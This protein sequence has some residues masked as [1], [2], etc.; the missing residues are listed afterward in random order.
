MSALMDSIAPAASAVI[1]SLINGL[2]RGLLLTLMVWFLL[3][4]MRRINAATRFV[5]WW[6]ALIA[7]VALPLLGDRLSVAAPD[8]SESAGD[9]QSIRRGSISTA[10]PESA[11][12]RIEGL[13]EGSALS[14]PALSA[15]DSSDQVQTNSLVIPVRFLNGRWTAILFSLWL[16]GSLVMLGRV[17]RSYFHLR[18]LKRRMSPLPQ[19]HTARLALCLKKSIRRVEIG[20]S[21]E[22]TNP[23]VAGFARPTILIPDSLVGE[24]TESEFDTVV[25]HELAHIRRWDDWLN[26]AQKIIEAILFFN[27]SV[28]W[29]GRQISLEREIACDDRVVSATGQ[30]KSYAACLL[31]L[32][33]IARFR[34]INLLAPGAV[35]TRNQISRRIEML[36]DRKRNST[37][38]LSRAMISTAI[39]LLAFAVIKGTEVLP[40]LAL[41]QTAASTI[42]GADQITID[43]PTYRPETSAIQRI[44][45]PSEPRYDGVQQ[46]PQ[47][48]DAARQEI[49]EPKAPSPPSLPQFMPSLPQFVP[50]PP[51][52]VAVPPVYPVYPSEKD[53]ARYEEQK[54]KYEEQMRQYE[55]EMAEYDKQMETYNAQMRQYEKEMA[56]YEKQMKV[57]EEQMRRYEE[58]MKRYEE[59]MRQFEQQIHQ[60]VPLVVRRLISDEMSKID[61]DARDRIDSATEQVSSIIAMELI[62]KFRDLKI[63]RPGGYIAL[64]SEMT[65]KE[66]QARLRSLFNKHDLKL[67]S[68]TKAEFDAALDRLSP[69]LQWLVVYRFEK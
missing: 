43:Q 51:R 32:I 21:N 25:L 8:A 37:V 14:M 52:L 39:A 48:P 67:D 27:P 66:I 42:T 56:E 2:V 50:S 5:V 41:D 63:N 1:G 31:K 68:K 3:G 36:M 54:R 17:S 6:A 34:R 57:Y 35:L 22:I 4:L 69:V 53:R 13:T 59:E 58:E 7:V 61:T 15:S 26:L 12:K 46:S 9:Y 55:K 60:M 45:K 24:L 47:P 64:V 65:T 29:I 33:E 20:A 44:A 19:S 16:I 49:K 28:W 30:S 62:S 11:P 10:Q 38:R 23:V 18:R 40:A